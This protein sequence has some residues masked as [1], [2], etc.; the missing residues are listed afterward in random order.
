MAGRLPDHLGPARA[1]RVH[2]LREVQQGQGQQGLA[3]LAL[4]R[5][6]RRGAG[7]GRLLPHP[8]PGGRRDQR[9]R[10]PARHQGTRV[11]R[12]GRGGGRR[13]GRRPGHRRR[14]RPGGRDVH[15]AQARRLGGLGGRGQGDEGDRDRH[16][17][18]RPAE[19]HLDRAGY[20]QDQVRQ[21]HAPGDRLGVQLH[22]RRGHHHAG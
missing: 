1:V 6:G 12:A 7:R 18:D 19:E 13:G 14:A 8:G 20:A 15:L 4:L 9:G 3:R 22:R 10:A 21:D 17:Q 11:V 16:R 5:R 2:V